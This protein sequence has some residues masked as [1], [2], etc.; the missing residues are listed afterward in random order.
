MAAPSAPHITVRQD[1]YRIY[2]RWRPIPTATDYTLY[3]QEPGGAW[4]VEDTI[5]DDDI[6]DDGWF[7]YITSPQAGPM[8][9]KLTA[10]NVGAEESAASNE[11]QVNLRGAGVEVTPTSA[12]NAYRRSR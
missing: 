1:G 5:P 11:V 8:N 3:L 4:G 9:V 6:E 7:F 10:S 12:L 2:V